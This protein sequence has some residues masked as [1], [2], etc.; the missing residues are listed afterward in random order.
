MSISKV[1][2]LSKSIVEVV[3]R[4]AAPLVGQDAIVGVLGRVLG[5]SDAEGR[6]LFHALE[7]EVDAVGVPLLHAA[8]RGQHVIL[9][10]HA[11]SGPFKRD[12]VVAG[13]SFHP[14]LVV[15]GA[16]A[17]HFLAHHRK[18]ADLGEEMDDLL[19]AGR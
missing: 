14:V 12:A 7:D 6:P 19:G 9:F 1:W 10:A 16:L 4:E 8:Q 13:K 18:A 15:V 17:E 3:V 5:H 11:L 2:S